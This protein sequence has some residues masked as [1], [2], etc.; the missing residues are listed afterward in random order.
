MLTRIVQHPR[1]KIQTNNGYLFEIAIKIFGDKILAISSSW[2]GGLGVLASSPVSSVVVVKPK[3][4]V[5]VK[6]RAESRKNK[7]GRRRRGLRVGRLNGPID[8]P[9]PKAQETD[10]KMPKK[11]KFAEKKSDTR[12]APWHKYK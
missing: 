3:A 4:R 7:N 8:T 1:F 6:N 11:E 5:F 9:D 12:R 10:A 2:N